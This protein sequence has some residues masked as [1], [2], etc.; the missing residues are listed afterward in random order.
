M[1]YR[2]LRRFSSASLP[3]LALGLVAALWGAPAGA[4]LIEAGVN[5]T[6]SVLLLFDT[7]GSMEWLVEDDTYPR[8]LA[9][10]A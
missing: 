7:S 4:Q 2:A 10:P 5:A 9:D 8:C 6:P 3:A 1:M